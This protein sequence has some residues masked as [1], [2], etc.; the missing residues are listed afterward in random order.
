[1][2]SDRLYKDPPPAYHEIQPDVFSDYS[3]RNANTRHLRT[4]QNINRHP[5]TDQNINDERV[6]R[7]CCLPF[8]VVALVIFFI[9]FSFTGTAL[10]PDPDD[11]TKIPRMFQLRWR[12][13]FGGDYTMV[14]ESYDTNDFSLSGHNVTLD[15]TISSAESPIDTTGDYIKYPIRAL[16][17]D[18]HYDMGK[19]RYFII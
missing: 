8:T 7:E 12:S 6:C 18:A 15:D 3:H 11:V 13:I 17:L 5:R 4:N 9:Y 10:V 14:I 2:S 16:I 19:Y 1:S